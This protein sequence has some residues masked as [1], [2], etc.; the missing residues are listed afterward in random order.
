MRSHLCSGYR[1]AARSPDYVQVR[2][3]LY[4]QRGGTADVPGAGTPSDLPAEIVP[5]AALDMPMLV[6]PANLFAYEVGSGCG[7]PLVSLSSVMGWAPIPSELLFMVS[8]SWF[9]R[10]RSFSRT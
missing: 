4:T 5:D 8:L 7:A 1:N 10:H 6:G 2:G 9:E 3:G